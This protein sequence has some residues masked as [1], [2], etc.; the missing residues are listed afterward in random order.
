MRSG[1]GFGVP[2]PNRMTRVSSAGVADAAA[3]VKKKAS[4]TRCTWTL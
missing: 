2:V 3:Q 4:L 1:S